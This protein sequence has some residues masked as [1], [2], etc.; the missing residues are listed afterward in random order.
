MPAPYISEQRYCVDCFVPLDLKLH[1]RTIRC[2]TCQAR[3]NRRTH[4]ERLKE[5]RKNGPWN[6]CEIEGCETLAKKPTEKYCAAHAERQRLGMDMTLPVR[7]TQRNMGN[8]CKVDWCDRPAE[9]IGYCAAHYIRLQR[10][11][12]MDKP[13]R[14]SMSQSRQQISK[15]MQ[16]NFELKQ[17]LREALEKIETLTSVAPAPAPA[18]PLSV[19]PKQVSC[20]GC[21]KKFRSTGPHTRM[22]ERCRSGSTFGEGI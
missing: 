7:K 21:G 5:R 19:W 22:C 20:L 6:K 14:R 8:V 10:G 18:T 2:R 17:R 11:A 12:D 9:T 13:F 16:E 4:K 1:P 3:R 15:L